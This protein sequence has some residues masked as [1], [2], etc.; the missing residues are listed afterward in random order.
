MVDAQIGR[1]LE[2]LRDAG[3]EEETV[4]V[5]TSDHGDLDAAHRLEHKSILYEEAVRVPLIVSHKGVTPP[6]TVDTT[7]LVSFGLDLIP[8][9][10]DYA[11]IDPPQGLPGRSVRALAEG[12]QDESW[13]D[14][15]VVESRAG[16][17]LRTDRFK[18]NVYESGKHRE[19][20]IDLKDDPGEMVNLAENPDYKDV[21]RQHRKRLR[22]WVEETDDAIAREYIV[23]QSEDR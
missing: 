11:G 12:R 13:R 19:Q 22:G 8:T 17:M 15:L 10:C 9:L 4:I 20:L 2:A 1:V 18:Y 3:L 6:G 14:Q 16:R 21:L 23:P 5:F 7:H